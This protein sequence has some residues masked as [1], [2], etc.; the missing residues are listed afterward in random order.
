MG[1]L[2]DTDRLELICEAIRY[3]QRVQKMGGPA[4]VW[5][6]A[7]REAV[8]I[9]WELRRGPK[10]VAAQYRSLASR[11]LTFGSQELVYEHAI[12]VMIVQDKLMKLDDL[13]PKAVQDILD[14]F[15]VTCIVTKEEDRKLARAMPKDW[16]GNDTLARYKL[17]GIDVEQN[18]AWAFAP[19][20]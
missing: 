10:M 4:A 20:K 16:D 17:A 19:R 8:V 1:M 9:T 18:P 13:N 2:N 5:R 14:R 12:P 15:L 7:L 3:C 6:R 11:S